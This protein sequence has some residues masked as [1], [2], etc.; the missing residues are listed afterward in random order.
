MATPITSLR[1]RAHDPPSESDRQTVPAPPDQSSRVDVSARQIV[2]AVPNP[3][4]AFP[5][6]NSRLAPAWKWAFS[7]VRHGFGS[8][9]ERRYGKCGRA[10]QRGR[11]GRAGD[12]CCSGSPVR[13]FAT[14][15]IPAGAAILTF[16]TYTPQGARSRIPAL[17]R[18]RSRGS[19]V[20]CVLEDAPLPTRSLQREWK[21]C[22]FKDAPHGNSGASERKE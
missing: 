5:A 11:D 10:R 13:D 8:Y 14:L 22:V 18:G 20:G 16:R 12:V 6:L 21:W 7:P 3:V 4:P 9:R 1:P 17:R 15:T 2:R 19:H